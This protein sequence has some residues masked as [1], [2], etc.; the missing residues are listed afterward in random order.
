MKADYERCAREFGDKV[1]V[2][3]TY[4][5]VSLMLEQV[6]SCRPGFQLSRDECCTVLG[7]VQSR[8]DEAKRA[9]GAVEVAAF[10]AVAPPSSPQP[11]PS[12][13]QKRGAG[14]DVLPPAKRRKDEGVEPA[15]CQLC[16]V[17]L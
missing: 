16:G 4:D 8:L 3:S 10:A 6:G 9:T 1:I 7:G 13:S 11:G 14:G 17:Y 15:V 5:V 12:G 2:Q